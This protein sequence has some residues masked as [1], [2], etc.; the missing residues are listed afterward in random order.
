MRPR[1]CEEEAKLALA[2]HKK[3]CSRLGET[4]IL[5]KCCFGTCWISVKGFAWPNIEQDEAFRASEIES[6]VESGPGKSL[7]DPE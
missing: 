2:S 4:L 7:I 6:P 3:W 1:R 5:A